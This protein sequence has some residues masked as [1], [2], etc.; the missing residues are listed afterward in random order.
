MVRWCWVNFQCK[1]AL[2]IWIIIGQEPFALAV[3]MGGGLFG[4]FYPICLFSF[5]S[6]SP[7]DRPISTEIL[8]QRAI[9][10]KTANQLAFTVK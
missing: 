6:S 2:L 1:G 3:G 4:H 10:P 7:R 8:S 9:K 5:L